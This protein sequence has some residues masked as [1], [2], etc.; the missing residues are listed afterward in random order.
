MAQPTQ[1]SSIQP[2]G[3]DPKPIQSSSD[4]ARK[5]TTP[6]RTQSVSIS[7]E[8]EHLADPRKLPLR[9]ES[10][11]KSSGNPSSADMVPNAHQLH[12]FRWTPADIAVGA[13]L[14]VACGMVF[15]GFDFAYSSLSPVLAALLPGISSV[16]HAFWYFSGPLA[17]LIIRK[18]GAAIYVNLVGTIAEMVLGNGFSFGFVFVSAALQAIFSEIP[19]AIAAYRRYN[20]SL[21]ISSGALT[22]VEYGIYLQLFLYQGV[23]FLSPRGII[24]MI[25]EVVGGVLIAGVMSWLLFR[26]IAKTGALDRFASG[27]A[28]RA[29]AEDRR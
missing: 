28:M 1:P 25:S 2:Q 6:L 22:A 21:T 24:H 11:G 26:A 15:W 8:L 20:L 13:A 10:A 17:L 14:G 23:A 3:S 18:P 7:N 19:F 27:R 9:T 5:S 12:H 29:S 4:V 16:L